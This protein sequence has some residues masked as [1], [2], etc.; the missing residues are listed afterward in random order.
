MHVFNLR[1]EKYAV[2]LSASGIANRWNKKD[3][4][5]I[6]AAQC[7]S[8]AAL[9]LLVHK[10]SIHQNTSYKLLTI[11]ILNNSAIEIFD[12][13]RLPNQWKNLTAYTLLQEIGS[14]WYLSKRSLVM[15]IPSV[16]IPQ[17]YNFIINTLH[18]EFTSQINL[19][20]SEDFL[21]DERLK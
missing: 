21:W 20:N 19:I 1:S 10:N 16:I 17:E 8:L 15:Q 4:F 3:E 6:Y 13:F 2:S 5:V 9:E 11:E 7:I 18:P 12:K 14:E